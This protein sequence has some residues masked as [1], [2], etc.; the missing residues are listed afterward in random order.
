MDDAA[1][2]PS[3]L[4]GSGCRGEGIAAFGKERMGKPS[5]KSHLQL[6]FE[7]RGLGHG[8]CRFDEGSAWRSAGTSRRRS[9]MIAQ[10]E[11]GPFSRH[12]IAS[13]RESLPVLPRQ[14]AVCGCN[15]L[16]AWDLAASG[17][18]PRRTA[19]LTR[20]AT[21]NSHSVFCILYSVLASK[22]AQ[23]P[24]PRTNSGRCRANHTI[25][26]S[27]LAKCAP[28]TRLQLATAGEAARPAANPRTRDHAM[29]DSVQVRAIVARQAG[30]AFALL[31]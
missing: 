21:T 25:P 9:G 1:A 19:L 31:H 8:K 10:P 28:V 24:H 6:R 17:R 30:A 23:N 18:I 29:P 22:S 16:L 15:V 27:S 12:P 11:A 5:A 26:T 20:P 2:L 14:G 4:D 13:R 3:S 7:E